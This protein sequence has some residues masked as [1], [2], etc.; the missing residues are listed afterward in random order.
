MRLA[1]RV[2]AL[3]PRSTAARVGGVAV[4]MVLVA[5][6]AVWLL[7][8]GDEPADPLPI[9]ED[10]YFTASELDRAR[11]YRDGQL[12]L[13]VAGIGV[14]GAVVL[15]VALGHPAPVRRR[16]ERLAARPLA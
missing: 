1:R 10:D 12:W 15:A 9:A 11:D 14:E 6:V 4:A 16:L 2:R 3:T 7:R 13:M 5:E 8:P